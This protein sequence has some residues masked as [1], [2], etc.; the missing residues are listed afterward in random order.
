M[1]EFKQYLD[2]TKIVV[3][4]VVVPVLRRVGL[5]WPVTRRW[6]LPRK[7]ASTIRTVCRCR[8]SFSDQK[9]VVLYVL[10][11]INWFTP[12][13]TK[14]PCRNFSD[15]DV[16][17]GCNRPIYHGVENVL[18]P[19]RLVCYIR[20]LYVGIVQIPTWLFCLCNVSELSFCFDNL[21]T[22]LIVHTC[23]YVAD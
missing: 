17:N 18:P 13:K 3:V 8:H 21:Q 22:L 4:V 23:I 15:S 7:K 16:E 19:G 11:M 5:I 12:H 1:I 14:K 20:C 10:D 2:N 6:L 9:C